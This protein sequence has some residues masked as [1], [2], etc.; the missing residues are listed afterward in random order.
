MPKKQSLTESLQNLLRIKLQE[1]A[2]GKFEKLT[3]VV[4]TQSSTTRPST[5]KLK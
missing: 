2:L 3:F 4:Y 5:D 1:A